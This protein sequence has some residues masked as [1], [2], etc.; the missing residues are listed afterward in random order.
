MID[1]SVVAGRETP[2]CVCFC[3]HPSAL[4]PEY[5]SYR[6]VPV[7]PPPAFFKAG[8]PLVVSFEDLQH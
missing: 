4:P 5:C 3:L 2:P 6:G 7:C 8:G 1:G